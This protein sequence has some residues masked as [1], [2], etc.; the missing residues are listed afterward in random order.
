MNAFYSFD[1]SAILNGRRDLFRP[2]VFA[3][4]WANIED[5]IAT[6]S[7]RAVSIVSD[8]LSKRS[9]EPYQWA[10]DQPQLYVPLHQEIQRAT[11]N[12]LAAHPRL[13]GNGGGR[14]GAD[15][16]VIAL[17]MVNH[18]AVVTDETFSGNLNKPRIPDVCQ[19]LS[20][21]CMTVMDFVEA[22]HWSF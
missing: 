11:R 14:N 22:Q 21:P 1:T 16:F 8:E 3:G 9:D 6:G 20:V 19:A 17:A 4:M 10:K 13:V 2:N 5:M 15:P 18:G 7:V 12:I